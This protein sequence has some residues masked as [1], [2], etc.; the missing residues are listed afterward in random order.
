MGFVSSVTVPPV[1]L[2]G[3]LVIFWKQHVDLT[4][5]FQSPNFVDCY[6]KSNGFG[7]FLSFVY[8]HP[9]PSFRN[10][11]WERLQ[12]IAINRR[13]LPWFIQGDFN[14]LL[15]NNEKQGGRRRQDSS[16]HDLRKMVRCCDFTDLKSLG[17]RFSWAGQRGKH[18][19]KCCLDRTRANG[20]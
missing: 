6:V 10:N 3:G 11:L 1:G 5:Y 9:N 13:G 2:S 15:S 20:E 18:Y 16:F 17:N 7:F 14:E 19:I 4:V 8:G 12:R